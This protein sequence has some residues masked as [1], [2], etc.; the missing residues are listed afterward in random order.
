MSFQ[1]LFLVF[2]MLLFRGN[3]AS[4]LHNCD[5]M[6]HLFAERKFGKLSPEVNKQKGCIVA[7]Q[8]ICVKMNMS[9]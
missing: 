8:H 5:R 4:V 2:L 1:L 3:A 7:E 6:I 9:N